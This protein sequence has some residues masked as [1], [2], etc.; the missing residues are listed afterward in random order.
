MAPTNRGVGTLTELA[1]TEAEIVREQFASDFRVLFIRAGKPS[2]TKIA[3][4]ASVSR[5]TVYALL[6]GKYVPRWGSA[7]SVVEALGGDVPEWSLRWAALSKGPRA[8]RRRVSEPVVPDQDGAT[9]PVTVVYPVMPPGP[10]YFPASAAYGARERVG[11]VAVARTLGVVLMTLIVLAGGSVLYYRHR[12][13]QDV[14]GHGAASSYSETTGGSA[15][16]WSDYRTAGGTSGPAL[17]PQQTIEVACRVQGY[18]VPDKNPW[19][20]RISSAPWSG[21]Y[22]ATADAFYNNG[23]TSG[24][25][26]N[27]VLVDTRVPLC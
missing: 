22:Y 26:K 1:E 24:T 15:R 19:W 27:G 13:H 2:I 10:D 16:A 14:A 20:Y 7:L 6:K 9:P 8:A 12:T 17:T 25:L 3:R 4:K 18:A 11:P 5:S 21:N 23:A